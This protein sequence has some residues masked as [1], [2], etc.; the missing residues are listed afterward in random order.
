MSA[1]TMKDRYETFDAICE[2]IVKAVEPNRDLA[3]EKHNKEVFYQLTQKIINEHQTNSVT[4]APKAAKHNFPKLVPNKRQT[5]ARVNPKAPTED[6]KVSTK[7]KLNLESFRRVEIP[8]GDDYFEFNICGRP[9]TLAK[10]K[11]LLVSPI[12]IEYVFWTEKPFEVSISESDKSNSIFKGINE[13]S[14]IESFEIIESILNGFLPSISESHFESLLFLSSKLYFFEL[15]RSLNHFKESHFKIFDFEPFVYSVGCFDID[16]TFSFQIGFETFNCSTFSAFLLSQKSR[17]LYN[18]ENVSEIIL[19]IPSKFDISEFLKYFCDFFNILF[20]NAIE[21]TEESFNIFFE[22][23][24]Q[25]QNDQLFESILTFLSS[26]KFVTLSEKLEILSQCDIEIN[27]QNHSFEN[28]FDEIAEKFDSIAFEALVNIFPNSIS[29]ILKSSQLNV[30]SEDAKFEFIFEYIENQKE[31]STFLYDT[32]D[33]SKLSKSNIEMFLNSSQFSFLN[34]TILTSIQE[35][36]LNLQSQYYDTRYQILKTKDVNFIFSKGIECFEGKNI[37]Q[38]HHKSLKYFQICAVK[39]HHEVVYYL[40]ALHKEGIDIVENYRFALNYFEKDDDNDDCSSKADSD[41]LT[42]IGLLLYWGLGLPENKVVAFKFF[43]EGDSKGNHEST[44]MIGKYFYIGQILKQ[45]YSIAFEYFEKSMLNGNLEAII[46][47]AMLYASRIFVDK[48]ITQSYTLALHAAS[49]GFI[50][51]LLYIGECY[52]S[53]MKVEQNYCEALRYYTEA[54]DKGSVDA[55]RRIAYLYSK[56]DFPNKDKS[57]DALYYQLAEDKGWK[58]EYCE[59]TPNR[60][61]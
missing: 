56:K 27:N 45:D 55:L 17:R 12:L 47:L 40:H 37:P 38:D 10:S 11:I 60:F 28:L 14:V 29:Q 6:L 4:T 61:F 31:R 18:D 59:H 13:N 52:E 32:I 54:A 53:G 48:Y 30:E 42:Y 2:T 36:I 44:R 19:N 5:A 23:S 3:A 26:H 8:A 7:M 22:I 58:S 25:L 50:R 20:G 15:L 35:I 21:I 43:F 49:Q 33:F 34:E 39:G 16:F 41:S 57:K 9:F 1:L 51:G 24:K 46:D